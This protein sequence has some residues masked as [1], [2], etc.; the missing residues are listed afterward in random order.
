MISGTVKDLKSM[1]RFCRM[2]FDKTL[3]TEKRQFN[4]SHY[5]RWRSSLKNGRTALLDAEPWIT[6]G[7][8]DHLKNG[9]TKQAEFSSG[10]RWIDLVSAE[11][12]GR[13]CHR[14]A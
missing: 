7:A 13:S 12:R 14:R 3:V 8:R 9:L 6:F 1:F 4:L 5:R 11:A 2:S 10:P